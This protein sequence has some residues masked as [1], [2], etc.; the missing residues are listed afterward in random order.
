MISRPSPI[1]SKAFKYRF[2]HMA[3]QGESYTAPRELHHAS[4]VSASGVVLSDRMFSF[5]GLP[6]W[7]SSIFSAS[8]KSSSQPT[9][10]FY[11]YQVPKKRVLFFP[12]CELSFTFDLGIFFLH[13]SLLQSQGSL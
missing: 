13:V 8:R 5:L 4:S 1:Q 12:A 9:L 7:I 10:A 3:S 11:Q 2:R 6:R